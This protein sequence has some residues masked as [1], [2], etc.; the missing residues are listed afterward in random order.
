MCSS[1]LSTTR[2]KSPTRQVVKHKNRKVRCISNLIHDAG[3]GVSTVY[4]ALASLD[5]PY[6]KGAGMRRGV[7]RFTKEEYSQVIGYVNQ[8]RRKEL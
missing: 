5:I 6:E 3:C 4:S 1:D 2:R 7:H 8:R